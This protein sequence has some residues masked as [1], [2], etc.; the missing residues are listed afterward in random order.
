[1]KK[2]VKLKKDLGGKLWEY[3]MQNMIAILLFNR[4]KLIK[5][6]TFNN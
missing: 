4:R 2:M 3:K 6:Q 1:M 5:A